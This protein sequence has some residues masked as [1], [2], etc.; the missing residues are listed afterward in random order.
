MW[1]HVLVY[2]HREYYCEGCVNC[3]VNCCFFTY[4]FC[5]SPFTTTSTT[6]RYC[7][8]T[9]NR[10][11]GETILNSNLFSRSLTSPLAGR[12]MLPRLAPLCPRWRRRFFPPVVFLL[13]IFFAPTTA[14][15]VLPTP[16]LWCPLNGN[17]EC[18]RALSL[19]GSREGPCFYAACTFRTTLTRT[20]SHT[21]THSLTHT[22][23]HSHTHRSSMS[24]L[25]SAA[26]G[27]AAPSECPRPSSRARRFLVPT[28]CAI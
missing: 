1:T 28:F 24:P 10:L 22:L 26:P 5:L 9:G 12:L 18:V 16:H 4:A 2:S 27:R 20:L 11:F 3:C 8:P 23:T 17:G 25:R 13:F 19:R 21:H 14:A 7:T 6:S 15:V